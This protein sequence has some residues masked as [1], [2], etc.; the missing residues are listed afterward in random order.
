M[1]RIITIKFTTLRTGYMKPEDWERFFIVTGI[2]MDSA[3]THATKFVDKMLMRESL[4]MLD[5]S[6]LKERGVI[7][8]GEAP[9]IF[10]QTKEAT[11]QATYTHAPVAKPPQLN[12]EMTQQQ[13]RKFQ[14]DWDVF[15][16]MK[17]MPRSQDYIISW[18][19]AAAIPCST[20]TSLP[21]MWLHII[22]TNTLQAVCKLD[23]RSPK[24]WD[25]FIPLKWSSHWAI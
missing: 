14:I 13:F 2:S 1:Y 16:K 11:S 25:D 8:M 3:K 4:K 23:S 21:A 10:K 5:Q 15:T 9:C 6:I 12:L 20:A 7:I 19:W 24:S 22:P 18:F 17:N